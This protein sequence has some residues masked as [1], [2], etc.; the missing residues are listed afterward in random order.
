MHS[1]RLVALLSYSRGPIPRGQ[2]WVSQRHERKQSWCMSPLEAAA[3]SG[4]ARIPSVQHPGGS[5]AE[6]YWARGS[7]K[8]HLPPGVEPGLELRALAVVAPSPLPSWSLAQGHPG[9]GG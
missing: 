9:A 8:D 7:L 1:P 5:G 2:G 3:R 4:S 6:S